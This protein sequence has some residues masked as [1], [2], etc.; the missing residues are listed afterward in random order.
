MYSC[1]EINT[2]DDYGGG[3][4]PE[5]S[6]VES[7]CESYLVLPVV[8]LRV[9]ENSVAKPADVSKRRVALVSE[10]LQSQHG[11]VAAVCERGLE[12]FENLQQNIYK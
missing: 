8:L 3:E 12:E 1:E 5:G 6:G 7:W 11:A 2:G 4:A 9:A 10:L